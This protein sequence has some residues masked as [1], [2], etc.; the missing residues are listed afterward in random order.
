MF[1]VA[2][3]AG[4]LI[5]PL[6][7]MVSDDYITNFLQCCPNGSDLSHDIDASPPLGGHVSDP[8]NLTFNSGQSSLDV[9]QCLLVGFSRFRCRWLKN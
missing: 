9:L 1:A 4:S 3:C 5:E 8:S 7:H 6:L 2:S